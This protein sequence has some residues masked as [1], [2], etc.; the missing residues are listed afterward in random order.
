MT[1]DELKKFVCSYLDANRERWIANGEK[2]LRMPELAY[3]EQK[4]AAFVQEHFT[5]LGLETQS[6][7]AITGM[8]SR[9]RIPSRQGTGHT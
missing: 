5:N 6:G 1:K 2:L 4:T 7:L 3:C 8:R 9:Q